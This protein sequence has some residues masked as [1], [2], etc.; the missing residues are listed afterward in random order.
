MHCEACGISRD[1]FNWWLVDCDINCG[2]VGFDWGF[3]EELWCIEVGGCVSFVELS[4]DMAPKRS[5]TSTSAPS[6]D[7]T[8]FL[9]A[10][11]QANFEK[12]KEKGFLQERS[13]HLALDYRF[14]E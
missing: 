13:L 11:A 5:R 9:S 14:E 10:E 12:I 7:S 1:N 2:V 4:V 3:L 6:F 8:R